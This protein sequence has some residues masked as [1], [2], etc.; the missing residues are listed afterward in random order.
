M[1]KNKLKNSQ[2]HSFLHLE[3]QMRLN[4]SSAPDETNLVSL[5]TVE[6]APSE[7]EGEQNQKGHCFFV[8]KVATTKLS[9]PD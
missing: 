2:Q 3:R 1:K 7:P 9:A 8:T 6:A 4:G 5:N